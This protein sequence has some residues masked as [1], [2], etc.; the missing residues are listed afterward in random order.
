MITRVKGTNITDDTIGSDQIGD[1]TD[2]TIQ[3]SQEYTQ[4][5]S[6]G[7]GTVTY[8]CGDSL[9]KLQSGMTAN[10]SCDFANL[11]IDSTR[12]AVV[13]LVLTQGGTAYLPTAAANVLIN[14]TNSTAIKWLGGNSAP[15]GTANQTDVASFT[16]INTGSGYIVLGQVAS[17]S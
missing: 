16:I 11:A 15:T 7:S 14:G 8:N 12:A 1:L 17:Y 6:G 2:V 4:A 5:V 9:I 3:T 13:T 10:W